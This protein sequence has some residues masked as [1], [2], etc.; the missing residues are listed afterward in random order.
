M[1]L[2]IIKWIFAQLQVRFSTARRL[3]ISVGS[4]ATILPGDDIA[5]RPNVSNL[6]T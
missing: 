2:S 3:V 4:F 6:Y 5:L 1:E